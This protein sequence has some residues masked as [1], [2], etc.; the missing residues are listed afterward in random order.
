MSSIFGPQRAGGNGIY[1][2]QSS[3]GAAVTSRPSSD[4]LSTGWTGTP[5]NANLYANVN[6]PVGS[7]VQFVTSPV[8]TG[9]QGPLRMGLSSP[10]F[11]GSHDIPFIGNHNGTGT[12]QVRAKLL[13]AGLTVL[14]TSAWQALTVTHTTYTAN[15]TI[16]ATAT[17]LELEVQ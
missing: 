1:G 6:E 15:V 17:I 8:I 7:T 4:I 9:S 5:D 11:S 16:A 14:G 13:D 10:R 3:G 2:P 12:P